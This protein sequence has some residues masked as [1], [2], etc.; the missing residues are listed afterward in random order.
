MLIPYVVKDPATGSLLHGVFSPEGIVEFEGVM[1]DFGSMELTPNLY[2]A[3]EQKQWLLAHGN[4]GTGAQLV[5]EVITAQDA[6]SW[7][8]DNDHVAAVERHF[9]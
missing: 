1:K 6:R 2:W 9:G 4:T 5:Y 8:A 3:P 7:L